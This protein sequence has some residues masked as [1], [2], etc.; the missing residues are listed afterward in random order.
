VAVIQNPVAILFEMVDLRSP[1]A[2]RQAS[3][4]SGPVQ[5]AGQTKFIA[6]PK[7]QTGAG[8][9]FSRSQP[10]STPFPLKSPNHGPVLTSR[11]ASS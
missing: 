8:V 11:S 2:N 5:A 10:I 4:A 9:I 1:K 6:K 7:W 3:D